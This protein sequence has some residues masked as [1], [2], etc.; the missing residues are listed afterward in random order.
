MSVCRAWGRIRVLPKHLVACLKCSNFILC[1]SLSTRIM[2]LSLYSAIS[3][4]ALI[5]HAH[6]LVLVIIA[7]ESHLPSKI[8]IQFIHSTKKELATLLKHYSRPD[9]KE[10]DNTGWVYLPAYSRRSL[11]IFPT[12]WSID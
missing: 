1:L 7:P 8:G 4:I 6:E 2:F 5:Q 12:N 3:N 9:C 10:P 11:N